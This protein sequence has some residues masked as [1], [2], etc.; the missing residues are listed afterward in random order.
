MEVIIGSRSI[1]SRGVAVLSRTCSTRW[2][3]AVPVASRTGLEPLIRSRKESLQPTSVSAISP[4]RR[5]IINR[6]IADYLELIRWLIRLKSIK[7]LS[8]ERVEGRERSHPFNTDTFSPPFNSPHAQRAIWV[9]RQARTWRYQCRSCRIYVHFFVLFILIL[10]KTWY[11][12]MLY[13]CA[14]TQNKKRHI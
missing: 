8:E 7:E 11:W 3:C 9:I 6:R 13:A 12:V 1:A 2:F 14:Y 4:D 5:Q 10:Y